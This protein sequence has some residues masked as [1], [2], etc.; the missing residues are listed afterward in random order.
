MVYERKVDKFLDG[1]NI[2][3]ILEEF[4]STYKSK[5]GAFLQL[6]KKFAR[7]ASFNESDYNSCSAMVLDE[8]RI[9]ERDSLGVDQSLGSND[10]HD[11]VGDPTTCFQLI[12]RPPRAMVFY[13]A[14]LAVV[15]YMF[16]DDLEK[17]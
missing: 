9:L 14:E 7:L 16:N 4:D 12:W 3:E 8:F 6:C 17:Q 10:A 1:G 15:A 13:G 5:V 11:D 2:K